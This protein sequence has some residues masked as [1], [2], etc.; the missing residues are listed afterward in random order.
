LNPRKP[1]GWIKRTLIVVTAVLVVG[2]LAAAYLV[3]RAPSFYARPNYTAEQ[4]S[5]FAREAQ[6][7]LIRA[8]EFA[9]RA[10]VAEA[11]AATSPAT[12]QPAPLV[13]DFSQDQ[14]NSLI[15]RWG[16]VGDWRASYEKYITDPV[17]IFQK[18]RIIV[19]GLAK[20]LGTVA[21]LHFA[22]NVDDEGKLNLTL[23]RVLGGAL[24]MPE[25]MYGS[26]V[27][28]LAKG[29][30]GRMAGWRRAVALNGDGT[31]NE[32]AV[33]TGM[34]KMLLGGLTGRPSDPYIFLPNGPGGAGAVPVRVTRFDVQAGHA[35]LTIQPLNATERAAMIE[36][37]KQPLTPSVSKAE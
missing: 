19:A 17:V 37:L 5:T 24:P 9:N 11:G 16:E 15:E 18:D 7:Q 1:T 20:D 31:V 25:G 28:K 12:T 23:E 22:A 10:R 34:A 3:R 35:S 6:N 27:D 36:Q 26:Y 8:S 32:E 33:I 4:R 30:A 14:V 21:S 2:A 13:V 29:L